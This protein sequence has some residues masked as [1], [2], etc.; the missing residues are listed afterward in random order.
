[1][2]VEVLARKRAVASF[3]CEGCGLRWR[4]RLREGPPPGWRRVRAGQALLDL[5]RG[6]LAIGVWRDLPAAVEIEQRA[7]G[8]RPA[9]C[10]AP[11]P[12]A[13]ARAVGAA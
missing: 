5:C 11:L 4:R 6:C 8:R 3:R 7:L 2:S 9:L 12:A 1:M 10:G 13:A